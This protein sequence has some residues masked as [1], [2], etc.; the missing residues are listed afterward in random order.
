M[1]KFFHGNDRG[2]AMLTA[3]V[4]IIVLSTVFISFTGRIVAARR[5]AGDYKDSVIRKIEQSNKEIMNQ[6]DL[7]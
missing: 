3:L 7:N 4:L 1:L 2:T 5:Y 6:Y